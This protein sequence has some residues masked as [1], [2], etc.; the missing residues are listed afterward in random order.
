M[1]NAASILRALIV[2]AIC[3]PL[4]IVVGVSAVSLVNSPSYS[5]FGMFGV[6]ALI[7][8]APILLRCTTPC[9]C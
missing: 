9:W 8:S 2:Y 1:N 5:N 6:L 7:L 4:A 3:I